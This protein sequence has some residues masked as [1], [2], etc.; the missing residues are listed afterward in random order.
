MT[1]QDYSE[2]NLDEFMLRASKVISQENHEEKSLIINSLKE[3]LFSIFQDKQEMENFY[4][5]LNSIIFSQEELAP[6]KLINSQPF[7]LY[8]I[9][10]SFN[11]KSSYYY[12]DY[13][14]T[15]LQICCS[16]ENNS[17][18][19]PFLSNIFA[20]VIKALF[21]DESSNKL[22][23]KKNMILEFNKKNKLYEKILNFCINN[24][25]T[26]EKIKQS[27]GCLLL[28]E[29]VEKCPLI[30]EEKNF[31]NIFKLISEYLD[32]HWFECKLDLLNCTLSLIFTLGKKFKI[33]SNICLFKILDFFTDEDWMKRKLAV[34]I[35]YTLIFYCKEEILKLKDNIIEFLNVLKDDPV[36]KVRELCIQTL[37]FIDECDPDNDKD[38]N[39]NLENIEDNINNNNELNDKKKEENINNKIINNE[40]KIKKKKILNNKKDIKDKNDKK[41]KKDNKEK[42]MIDLDKKEFDNNNTIKNSTGSTKD[43]KEKDIIIK[44]NITNNKIIKENIKENEDNIEHENI[45]NYNENN[46]LI[47][48]K[49]KNKR[50]NEKYGN[51]LNN[52]LS[53]MKQ[54]QETQNKLNSLLEN[55]RCTIDNNYSN[56]NERLKI[57]ENQY[58]KKNHEFKTIY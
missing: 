51:S 19:F 16:S 18:E 40:N 20:E 6:E 1:E 57:L 9:I 29:F 46:K 34:N 53:Q 15:S 3:H 36:D 22:L 2:E 23:I 5:T 28:T 26:N 7:N 44:E 17:N 24:I 35:V 49:I 27:F 47:E 31:E 37:N 48:I 13:F 21:A 8:P 25:K 30:K 10:Y 52:I 50:L 56:L 39:D 11:P 14:L 32:D 4:K 54:I 42:K 55:V 45:N 58:E 38:N 12:I 41:Y 43:K 33:Y